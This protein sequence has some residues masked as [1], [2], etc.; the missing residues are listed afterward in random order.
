MR[1]PLSCSRC[2]GWAGV[3]GRPGTSP[4]T[5]LAVAPKTVGFCVDQASLVWSDSSAHWNQ[6]KGPLFWGAIGPLFVSGKLEGWSLWHCNVLVKLVSRGTW[7]QDR[8]SRLL[9]WEDG[10]CQLCHDGPGTTCRQSGTCMFRK[11]CARRH[12]L[13]RRDI[14]NSSQTTF[15]LIFPQCCQQVH[16]SSHAQFRGT[17][18]PSSSG[19]GAL[20]RAGWAVVA[21][22]DVGKLKPAA[23]GA[24]PSDALPGETSRDGEDYA[25][26]MAGII[27]M[28][29]LTLHID[30]AGTIAIINEAKCKA[31]GFLSPTT[32]SGQSRR[33]GTIPT[34]SK[35]EPTTQTSLQ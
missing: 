23:F 7:T 13:L 15:F 2:C 32:R 12:V 17:I 22:D 25:A 19:S 34:Y 18:G 28:D 10:R 14:G 35:G 24:V 31:L 29:P 33:L 6:S 1:L 5:A 20:R 16:S 8:L 26:A 30:C 27:T 21:V 9:G 11:K 3:L 4:T